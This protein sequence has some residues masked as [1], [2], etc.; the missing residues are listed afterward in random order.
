MRF[1]LKI[2]GPITV[3]V[4]EVKEPESRDRIGQVSR[5][6]LEVPYAPIEPGV[7]LPPGAI[8]LVHRIRPEYS[9]THYAYYRFVSVKSGDKSVP[10]EPEVPATTSLPPGSISLIDSTKPKYS[11]AYYRF[12]SGKSGDT[13]E[14]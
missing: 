14:E 3:E 11:K 13:K 2:I 12:F 10:A 9:K 4:E 1:I 7:T 5:S 8:L 6:E